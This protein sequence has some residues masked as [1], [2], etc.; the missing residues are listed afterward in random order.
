MYSSLPAEP[1]GAPNWAD[2]DLELPTAPLGQER[3]SSDDRPGR[4][5][6]SR[7]YGRD[8]APLPVVIDQRSL[9]REPPFVA[10]VGNL[11]YE[12]N[13]DDVRAFFSGVAV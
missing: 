9:P 3:S 4:G 7:G 5:P 6:P 2:V 11:S 13:E 12:A 10:L 8:Q 1:T